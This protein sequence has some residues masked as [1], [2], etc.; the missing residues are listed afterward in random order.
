[1]WVNILSSLLCSPL[2]SSSLPTFC[3]GFALH[4]SLHISS[5]QSRAL[6]YF[7]TFMFSSHP[8]IFHVGCRT[9][10]STDEK[11]NGVGWRE[12][13][14]W[15]LVKISWGSLERMLCVKELAK[16]QN[17]VGGSIIIF[18]LLCMYNDCP[19]YKTQDDVHNYITPDSTE[20]GASIVHYSWFPFDKNSPFLFH[21]TVDYSQTFHI[22]RNRMHT[23]RCR[24]LINLV[25]SIHTVYNIVFMLSVASGTESIHFPLSWEQCCLQYL[26]YKQYFV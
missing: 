21:S 12:P 3:L 20:T 7:S 26:P 1:M 15:S 14:S 10:G 5:T 9:G 17:T 25:N 2:C 4:L 24:F 6:A 11:W 23:V 19:H 22:L 18:L 13:I 8:A 16:W